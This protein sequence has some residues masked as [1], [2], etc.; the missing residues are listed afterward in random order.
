MIAFSGGT[1][2]LNALMWICGNDRDFDFWASQGNP[3][4]DFASIHHY[5]KKSE[6]NVDSDIVQNGYH[7]TGG[8]LTVST[9]KH[10]NPF[11]PIFKDAYTELVISTSLQRI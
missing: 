7:G 5:I 8:P 6:N 11:A 4:W 3:G 2:S 1:T 10:S 9:Y